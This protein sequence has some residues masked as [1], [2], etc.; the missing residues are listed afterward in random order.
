MNEKYTSLYN[1]FNFKVT[2]TKTD[3][4][5]FYSDAG[6]FSYAS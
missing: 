2:R 5:F 4:M 3:E 1:L 6:Y